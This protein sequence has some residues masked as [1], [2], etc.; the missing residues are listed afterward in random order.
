MLVIAR[1]RC[2]RRHVPRANNVRPYSTPLNCIVGEGSC[3]LRG[4]ASIG[5][6]RNGPPGFFSS[7]PFFFSDSCNN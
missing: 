7:G 1:K 2:D 4:P 6:Y 5:L 3:P